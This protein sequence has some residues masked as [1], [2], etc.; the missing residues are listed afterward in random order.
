MGDT[1]EKDSLTLV[2]DELIE[3][4]ALKVGLDN[5]R[6]DHERTTAEQ[7]KISQIPAPSF[8]EDLRGQY[9]LDRF[10]EL[11]L[12]DIHRDGVG[13]VLGLR[14]GIGTAA[15]RRDR[16]T[17][18]VSAHL[19]TV[20]PAAT[21]VSVH[22]RDERLYGPGIADDGRGLAVLP[23]LIRAMD[24][25]ALQTIADV[26][27]VA[28]VGEEGTGDLRG[29]KHLFANPEFVIDGFLSIEPGPPSDITYLATGSHRLRV[30]YTGPGGHS[31]GNFGTP[32]A[33]HALGRAIARIAEVS[34]PTSPKTTFTVGVIEGGTS[35]N[36]I[37]AQASML[38][39]LR[40]NSDL[41]L[42]HL[43]DEITHLLHSAAGEENDRWNSH[44]VTVGI[45]QIG[46]R[47]SGSQLSDS[48]IV[49]AAVVTAR[50]VGYAPHLNDAQSTDA[51]VAIS[52][53]IPAVTL[54]GGGEAGGVHTLGEFFDTR[55]AYTGVQRLF[56]MIILLAGLRK[57]NDPILSKR[58]PEQSV[59]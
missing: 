35:V 55:D 36:T 18:V 6:H 46:R 29:V 56:M 8:S 32:S 52:L 11:G 4:A 50:A 33:I 31:F 41:H 53:G 21:D 57:L 23:A 48:P 51:N 25:A 44:A 59:Q 20:F 16:L 10:Y 49:R 40:S 12:T 7:V 28:T 27:F 1:D 47:P 2:L 15:A 26:W 43:E 42:A 9:F 3:L 19:D 22:V 37:A 54:G 58:I 38:V 13:N 5:I 24:T 14:S 34:V 30:T 45:E 17:L 39:D